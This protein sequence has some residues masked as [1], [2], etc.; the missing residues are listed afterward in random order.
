MPYLKS[1]NNSQMLKSKITPDTSGQI[2]PTTFQDALS[3]ERFFISKSFEI[4][5]RTT[6]VYEK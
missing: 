6:Y 5:I 1:T 4:V 2:L 3:T